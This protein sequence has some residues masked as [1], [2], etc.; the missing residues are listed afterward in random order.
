MV[1]GTPW[2]KVPHFP[3]L[4]KLRSYGVEGNILSLIC[5]FLS[6]RQQRVLINGKSSTWENV[7]AGVPQGSVLGPLLF[8]IYVNDLPDCIMSTPYLFADDVSLF[9]T[10]YNQLETSELLNNDLIAIS[11]WSYQWKMVFNPDVSKQA[12]KICFT[13]K[14]VLRDVPDLMFN[15]NVIKVVKEHKHLGLILDNHLSFDKHINDKTSKANKGIGVIKALFHILPRKSLLNIYL[16]FIRPHLDYCDIIYHKSSNDELSTFEYEANT[17]INANI[18]FNSRIESVQYN[19][20][21]AITGCIRGTSREKVY[22]ELGLMSLYDHS[23]F[24]RLVFFYK[25]K[26][27]ILPD[28]LRLWIPDEHEQTIYFLK[29]RRKNNFYTRTKKFQYSFFPHCTNAWENLSTIITGSLSLNIFKSRYLEFFSVKPNSVYRIHNHIGLKYLTR[30]RVGLSHLK[31]HKF[32]HKF[33]DTP[34]KFCACD[35]S[36]VESTEH[37]LLVCPNYHQFRHQLFTDLQTEMSIIPFK[38]VGHFCS[39]H[40]SA[41]R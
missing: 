29:A 24:H 21:L 1:Q 26:H 32:F 12:T 33:R 30:L 9:N 7:L 38:E 22:N 39:C 14:N 27:N 23:T 8:L 11:N 28:Y 41:H 25:I 37:Y 18:N 3:L 2:F 19:A 4:F 16:S 5:D 31:S 13:N 20:A 40:L 17:P 34:N 6:E 10:V 36:S 15:N 35:E